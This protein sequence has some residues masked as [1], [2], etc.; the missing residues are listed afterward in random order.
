MTKPVLKEVEFTNNLGQV[1]KPDDEV[2]IIT[3]GYNHRVNIRQGVYLGTKNDNASCRVTEYHTKYRFK[4]TGEDVGYYW[5]DHRTKT[6]GEDPFPRTKSG[7]R[8]GTPEYSEAYAEYQRLY[9]EWQKRQ[10][11]Y[12]AKYEEFKVPYYRHTTL[13]LNRIYKLDTNIVDI[14]RIN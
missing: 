2:V 1:I 14:G 6:F 4:E 9:G 5:S 3:S 11:E 12:A 10:L 8:Y 13:Q 7:L